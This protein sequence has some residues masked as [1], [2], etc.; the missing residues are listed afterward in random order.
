MKKMKKKKS[1]LQKMLDKLG[2]V[3]EPYERA[4]IEATP[5]EKR[6]LVEHD[7]MSRTIYHDDLFDSNIGKT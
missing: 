7:R 3:E 5:E 2:F 1:G 4:V 6:E